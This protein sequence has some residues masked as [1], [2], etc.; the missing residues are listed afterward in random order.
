MKIR[1]S[2]FGEVTVE[3]S[4][5]ISFPDGMVGFPD[6][7]TFVI[8]DG[9]DGTPFKWLQSAEVS[10]LA[11]VICDPVLFKGDYRVVVTAAELA[12][13][14]IARIEDAVVCVVLSI[15]ADPWR[16]TANLLGPVI[17][18]AERRLGKQLV[19]SGSEYTTKHP[20]FPQGFPA[21][22]TSAGA[23]AVPPAARPGV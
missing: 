21:P 2:R 22:G 11:F 6:A 1:T 15:P 23:A 7:R 14:H 17:F 20:V 8:F 19:L 10:E 13:L 4:A 12:D 18:N 3:D 16:M 9:P 5:A